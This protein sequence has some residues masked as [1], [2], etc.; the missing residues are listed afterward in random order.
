MRLTGSTRSLQ[1]GQVGGWFRRLTIPLACSLLVVLV[2]FG[3]ACGGGSSSP[4]INS[5]VVP[6]V[7]VS[8]SGLN[9]GFQTV[10][11]ASY[12]QGFTVTNNS[13]GTITV[14]GI[15]VSGANAGAFSVDQK[16]ST[17]GSSLAAGS[18]CT[19]NVIFT[20]SAQGSSSASVTVTDSASNSPQSVSLLGTGSL[21]TGTAHGMFMLDP[22]TSDNDC[23]P[24]GLPSSCYSASLVPTFLCFGNGTPAG[25]AQAGSGQPYLKGAVFQ[26]P[27]D[28]VQPSNG[29]TDFSSV[30]N[31][32]QPWIA[33]GKM[34]SF[35]F[36]P[37]SFGATNHATP[38]WYLTPATIAVVSEVNGIIAVQ[39]AAPMTFF[40]GGAPAAGMEIQITGTST[41]LD[42]NGTTAPGIWVIC[43][44]N[45]SG[46]ADPTTTAINAIGIAGGTIASVSIG[47]V[48]NPVYG[49]ADGSVCTSG[50]LPVQWRPNFI[51]AW[52]AFMQKAVSHYGTNPN[53]AYMR[54]GMGIGGQTNPTQ[55]IST[56][57]PNPTACQA[58]MTAYGFTSA[59]APWPSPTDAA[60]S[61]VQANWEAYL[62]KMLLYEQSLKSPKATIIT[63][64]PIEFAPDDLS[65]PDQTA[66]NAAG[67]G[68]GFGNQGLNKND[69]IN[70]AA[71]SPCAGG[72]WCANFQKY[73]GQ[74]PLEL[75][76]VTASDPTNANMSGSLTPLLPFAIQTGAQILELYVDDWMCTYDSSWTTDTNNN[77]V[78]T[79]ANCT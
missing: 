51:A 54:F 49:S 26:V 32:I 61:T 27:W 78:N 6:R 56:G 24:A 53:V 33:A 14:S 37:A 60:W 73:T 79:F 13:S 4:A 9:F 59:A 57:D 41:A 10:R 7:A 34:V 3:T 31:W 71:G 38:S 19:V 39:T 66:A 2:V 62:K 47:T 8:P 30:D 29:S 58:Q 16:T 44:H 63:I 22:P 67:A 35:V 17:C 76:T 45:T 21:L 69:P 65:T 28:I 1:T 48:G 50:V 75:Q 46:C 70:F 42:S 11:T 36:E 68:I 23:A 18:S 15:A 25:C 40:P 72:D 74:V 55:G 43:D 77:G 52:Q 64:S 20:P 5:P 12:P